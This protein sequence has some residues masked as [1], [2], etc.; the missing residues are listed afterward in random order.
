MEIASQAAAPLYAPLEVGPRTIPM[1]KHVSPESK[2]YIAM[3]QPNLLSADKYPATQDKEG[4]SR[5]IVE[6]NG[7]IKMMEDMV[8]PLCP[9][10]IERTTM[11]DVRVAV[12][13]PRTIAPRH[14]D[15]V[16]MN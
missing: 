1:T 13:S 11:N 15:R 14:H 8:L 2:E 7:M 6:V 4:W 10:T 16:L 3:P 5:N 9:V 12:V